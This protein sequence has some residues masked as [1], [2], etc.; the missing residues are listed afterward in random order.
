MRWIGV[1]S[2]AQERIKFNGL[3]GIIEWNIGDVGAGVGVNG[4]PPREVA[5]AIGLTPSASQIAQQ[6][7]LL[8]SLVLSGTDTFTEKTVSVTTKD[9]NTNLIEDPGFSAL[10]ANVVQ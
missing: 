4:A 8:R 5:F 2:P 1:Y 9:V 3:D 10:E 7:I 6:P